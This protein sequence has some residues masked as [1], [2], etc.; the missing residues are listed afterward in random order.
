[1]ARS[2]GDEL[3][4][5]KAGRLDVLNAGRNCEADCVLRRSGRFP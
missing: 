2:R 5:V 3:M 1:M 4:R